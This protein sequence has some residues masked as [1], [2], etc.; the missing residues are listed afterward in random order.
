MIARICIFHIFALFL[1]Y[2]A[3]SQEAP[4]NFASPFR[5]T[6][7]T[8]RSDNLNDDTTLYSTRIS[9]ADV[10]RLDFWHSG[11][12]VQD[13]LDGA[14]QS[15]P[16][17]FLSA[18]T[19]CDSLLVCTGLKPPPFPDPLEL[20]QGPLRIPQLPAP[21]DIFDGKSFLTCMRGMPNDVC[22]M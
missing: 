19:R 14:G 12:V 1:F 9:G 2:I 7:N 5:F 3:R 4:L 20:L 15:F 18:C 10:P 8:A 11:N 6:R 16:V 17:C 13:L 22:L 21:I